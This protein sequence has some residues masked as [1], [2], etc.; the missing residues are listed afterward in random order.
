MNF[1]LKIIIL[2]V[3][4]W[5]HIVD[6]FYLQGA[7]AAFKQRKWWK[8]NA[9]EKM[10]RNDYKI[11]LFIHAFSWSFMIMIPA[12]VCLFLNVIKVTPYIY[13]PW[14]ATCTYFHALIDNAKANE[15]VINLITDQSLHFVQIILTWLLFFVLF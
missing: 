15:K 14:I 9:P 12:A 10:Y 13:L 8:E 7:L 3:M 5:L 4:I 2:F 11:C 6:D 1:G